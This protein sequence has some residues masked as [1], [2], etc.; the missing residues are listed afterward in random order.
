MADPIRSPDGM[1]GPALKI[2]AGANADDHEGS[3][4]V[5]GLMLPDD[6]DLAEYLAAKVRYKSGQ[7]ELAEV[8]QCA[9]MVRGEPRMLSWVKEIIAVDSEPGPVH[10]YLAG[11]PARL[12]Q[13]AFSPDG[14]SIA[15]AVETGNTGSV[16]VWN[17]ELATPSVTK[18]QTI[19]DQRVQQ[20]SPAQV[21]QY[22]NGAGG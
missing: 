10:T 18:L 3:F 16:E 14:Q 2:C 13:A 19:A 21:Q 17:A 9:R 20:L 8:A 6:S 1:T 15:L 22:L 4:Q 12:D 11:L 7:R 5:G